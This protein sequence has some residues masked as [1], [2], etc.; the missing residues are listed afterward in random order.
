MKAVALL[1]GINVGG[2]NKLPMA[3]LT[4]IFDAVGCAAVRTY[5]QSGNVVF[6][7]PEEGLAD[8]AGAISARISADFGLA[9]PVVMRTADD[10]AVV[11]STNP[12]LQASVDIEALHVGFLSGSPSGDRLSSLDPGRSHPDAFA[13]LGREIFLNCPDG[14]ARTKLT[15][16]Y[17]DRKL[18]VVST[19]RNWRTVL[20]LLEMASG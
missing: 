19:L 1:R 20:K 8:L 3:D 16:D 2:K 18:G 10:L 7:A 9:V 14:L 6:E 12:F 5:I 11:A 4:R 17:F 13:V 15:N